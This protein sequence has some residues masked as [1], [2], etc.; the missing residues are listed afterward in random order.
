MPVYTF[1]HRGP[2]LVRS[3]FPTQR[4]GPVRLLSVWPLAENASNRGLFAVGDRATAEPRKLR[5]RPWVSRTS[6]SPRPNKLQPNRSTGVRRS[7]AKNQNVRGESDPNSD[8]PILLLKNFV[9][10][11]QPAIYMKNGCH[12][13]KHL[14]GQ[15]RKRERP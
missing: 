11:R 9:R 3:H 10:R 5:P 13:P 2:V 12:L 8:P 4:S 1:P 7:A 14:R 6:G 15:F